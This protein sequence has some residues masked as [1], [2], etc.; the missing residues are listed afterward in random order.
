MKLGLNLLLWTGHVT[1]EHFPLIRRIKAAGFDGVEVPLFEGSPAHYARLGAFL[2]DEGLACS[3][4]AIIPDESK[5]PISPVPAHRQAAIDHLRH[6]VD[7]SAALGADV[8]M[9]P[10]HSPLGVFSGQGPT[11]TEKQHGAA[12]HR[13]MA[14]HAQAAGVLCV[15]EWLNRFECYFLTTMD[16]AAAYARLV[17]HPS[18]TTMHDTFHANIEEK[19]VVASIRRNIAHIGHVHISENDRGTPGRGHI[20]F[21]PQLQAL[22]AGGYDGWLTIEAFGRALPSLAAATRVWRDFFPYAD[23][24]YLE[25]GPFVR[26]LWAQAAPR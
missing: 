13:A 6:A 10:F 15:L 21:L 17:N 23:E 20:D 18:F 3:A 2:K 14:E 25:G 11:E 7:C 24:V 19:D 4:V 9:G 16:D 8:L 12:V 1:E 5:S 26:K 22:R